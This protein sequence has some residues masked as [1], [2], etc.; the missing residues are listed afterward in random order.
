M[1]R[2]VY[3]FESPYSV[4]LFFNIHWGKSLLI[5]IKCQQ[6]KVKLKFKVVNTSSKNAVNIAVSSITKEFYTKFLPM[7]IL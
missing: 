6:K 1:D 2:K 4:Y 5:W 7:Y 3:T